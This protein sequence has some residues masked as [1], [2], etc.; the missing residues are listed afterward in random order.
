VR[1]SAQAERIH[2]RASRVLEFWREQ[3][4]S[5][6]QSASQW[7][8]QQPPSFTRDAS[9][10]DSDDSDEEEEDDDDSVVA[11]PSLPTKRKRTKRASY[12]EGFGAK[13]AKIRARSEL[14]KTEPSWALRAV[15]VKSND[16]LRQEVFVVQLISRYARLFASK[17]LPLYLKPYK[18]VA[19]SA[20]TGMIELVP[21][22]ISLDKLLGKSDY[23][24]SLR[25][26][27]VACYGQ[28][29]S[30]DFEAARTNFIQSCA[31]SAFA[32]YVLALKDRHNGNILLD[33]RGRLVH[34]DFGFVLGYAT[35]GAF[36]LEQCAPFKLTKNM[37]DLMGGDRGFDRFVDSLFAALLAARDVLD[38]VATLIEIMQFK[39]SFPCFTRANKNVNVATQFRER[40][41]PNV[42]DPDKLRAKARALARKALDNTGTYLYDVFQRKTNG[43]AY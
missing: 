2:A 40:H 25:K 42:H 29:G 33:S 15:I 26:H 35:G 17:K 19:L 14:A 32:C 10:D 43:I 6:T 24:G 23:A 5:A 16:D 38:E 27:F 7:V 36:S 31:A 28:E 1:L 20:T 22:S 30:H 39:S 34:I 12:G 21:D 11:A 4:H 8:Q 37:V 9:D 18:I 41:F 13:E 3:V